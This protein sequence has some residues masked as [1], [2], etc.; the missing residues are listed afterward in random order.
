[1]P[2]REK[3]LKGISEKMLWRNEETGASIAMIKFAKGSGIPQ[4]HYHS[5]NQFMICLSGRYEYTATG[6]TLTAGS[7]YCNPK[8]NVHGPAIAHEDTVVIE[9]YDGPHYP[10]KPSWYTD[11]RDAHCTCVPFGPLDNSLA[12]RRSNEKRATA[13]FDGRLRC[14]NDLR[15]GVRRLRVAA[16]AIR[17]SH[18]RH[19]P[20]RVRIVVGYSAGGGTDVVARVIGEKLAERLGQPVVIENRPGGGARI[21]VEYVAKSRRTATR[22]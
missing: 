10:E 14:G 5:S 22:S 8:G 15:T 17:R 20:T 1:M 7:F 9:I 19:S 3:S 12:R 21:A 16:A 6:V 2:W 13:V 18:R 11:E 4:P